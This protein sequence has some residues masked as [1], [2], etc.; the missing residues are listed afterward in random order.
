MYTMKPENS[1]EIS[2]KILPNQPRS[3]SGDNHFILLNSILKCV[4]LSGFCPYIKR[5]PYSSRLKETERN[6]VKVKRK[7][8][9]GLVINLAF[10]VIC[11]LHGILPLSVV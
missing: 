10:I 7:L 9:T 3:V 4:P 8:R 11:P 5:Y 6:V 1:S 2:N